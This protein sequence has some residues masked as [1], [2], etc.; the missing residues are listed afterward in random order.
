MNWALFAALS[1]LALADSLNPFTVAA[2]A[3]LLGTP[4]SLARSTA[5]LV[6]TY[7]VY[8]AGG[9]LLL[10]GWTAFF[11]YVAPQIPVWGF[12]A[13]ELVLGVI[14]AA[15][16]IWTWRKAKSGTPFSP[17]AEMTIGA[18]IAFALASTIADLS[19]AL[20][21]FTG[22]NRLAAT[23]NPVFTQM[24]LLGWYNLLYVL[25]LILLIG[26]KILLNDAHSAAVFGRARSIIDWCFAKLLTPLMGLAAVGLLIDGVR[27]LLT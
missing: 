4:K 6:T 26:A 5:F 17:P 23:E 18:T 2:Q 13:D 10:E 1:G 15:A 8:F 3:Y 7:I 14:L 20:P 9:V 21:Y 12:G 24:A 22:V 11:R 19:S 25:P 16:S 27:R